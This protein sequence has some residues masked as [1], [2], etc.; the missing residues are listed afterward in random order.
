MTIL[1][2]LTV[3]SIIQRNGD[4]FRFEVVYVGHSNVVIKNMADGYE[5][6]VDNE[7]LT[8][9]RVIEDKYKTVNQLK[10]FL[11][12]YRNSYDILVSI[13]MGLGKRYMAPLSRMQADLPSQAIYLSGDYNIDF[14]I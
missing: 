1:E 12:E 13:N 11:R 6:W 5:A 9:F 3:G 4:Q 7:E 2:R 14:E 8:H 10:T